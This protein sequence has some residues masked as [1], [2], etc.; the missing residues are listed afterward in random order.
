MNIL[1]EIFTDHYEKIKYTLHPRPAEMENIDKMINCGNPSYGSAMYGCTHCGNLKFVPFRCH[2]RFCPTC[3][4]KYSMDRTTSMSFKLVNVR[5]RHCVFTIDAS[6][7]DFF[8][9]DR[10][11]LNCLFHSV[12]SVVLRLFS[13]MNKHKN[14][15]PGFIMALHTFG[16]DLKWNPHIHCLI[17]EGGY[18]DD[19]FWRNVSHFNYTFLRNAFRTALLK[20]R[21]LRIGPSFKKFLPVVIWNMNT[22]SMFMPN[23]T[24]VTLRLLPN[25]LADILVALSLPLPGSILIPVILSLSIT[26]VTKMINMFKKPFLSWIL[27]NAL[28]ATS[29]KNISR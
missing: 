21:L 8:L 5:H 28:S 17:S 1:Q 10:S 24:V 29:L 7:R 15:T 2:S 22:A 6:L 9:Q 25:I 4:N 20:K 12:S 27:S 13:K 16:R 3:G 14:F 26:I 23:Q 11:L 19:A 18:S